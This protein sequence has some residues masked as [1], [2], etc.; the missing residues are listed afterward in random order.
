[1]SPILFC[2][3]ID[4]LL[5]NLS[6]SEVGCYIGLNF[7]G[8]IAYADDIL[9]ISRTP[10]GMRKLLHICDCYAQNYDI[11]FNADK[12]KS[13]VIVASRWRSLG[14]KLS[15]CFFSV[16]GKR[17]E[18]VK[19]YPHLGHIINSK[20]VDTDDIL[21]RRNHFAGQTNNV[22][23]FFDKMDLS[24]KIKLFRAYCS[25]VYGCEL[26]PLDCVDVEKFCSTW[27][28]ALRRL[29]GLPYDAHSFLLPILTDS[30][31]IFDE[32][33]KRSAR[34]IISCLFSRSQLV[35]QVARYGVVYGRY[36]SL[37]GSKSLFCS[38]RF[39]WN[40]D[41]FS[42][43]LINLDNNCLKKFCNIQ[44]NEN[45]RHSA[46]SLFELI[47]LREGHFVFDGNNHF[48]SKSQIQ[49]MIDAIASS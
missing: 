37:I 30:L 26:W 18:N 48:L 23:C 46:S 38:K 43:G 10:S 8:A 6:C 9:L 32:I 36:N 28:K 15:V 16:G 12:S 19:S 7:V 33:C 27:R 2:I 3:Y 34:F 4:D 20:F 29:L 40:F 31:P 35:R 14:K 24:V 1:V 17:I 44:I 39:K 22:L 25:S 41:D 45:Q 21:H 13:L 5:L 42:V 11:V 47:C 49:F